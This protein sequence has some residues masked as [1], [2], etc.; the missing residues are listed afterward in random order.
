MILISPR[1]FQGIGAQYQELGERPI[2]IKDPSSHPPSWNYKYFKNSCTMNW[3]RDHIFK[4]VILT[5]GTDLSSLSVPSRWLCGSRGK[6]L[7]IGWWWDSKRFH[8]LYLLQQGSADMLG[9][10]RR[11]N[12]P[13]WIR[14]TESFGQI[15]IRLPQQSEKSAPAFAQWAPRLCHTHPALLGVTDQQNTWGERVQRGCK[16]AQLGKGRAG[17]T[18][19]QERGWDLSR[20]EAES[21]WTWM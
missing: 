16:E 13:L 19:H 21:V 8:I 15:L 20:K 18:L 7:S 12:G 10:R 17:E 5:V 2:R 4:Y 9:S 6:H 14:D 3:S 11:K 1:K